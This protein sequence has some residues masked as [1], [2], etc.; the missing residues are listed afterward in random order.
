[1]GL[2]EL[3]GRDH[4]KRPVESAVVVPIDPAGG[5]VFH[6][7][8]GLIVALMEEGGADAL[9]LE[10]T[11]DAFHQAVVEGVADGVDE[12]VMPSRA[13]CSVNRIEVYW[14]PVG[15]DD[16]LGGPAVVRH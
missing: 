5:G 1:M 2:L 16:E 12:G 14:L 13:K 10:Q 15:V 4:A 9:G 8:A 7:G 11:D 6:L 3:S